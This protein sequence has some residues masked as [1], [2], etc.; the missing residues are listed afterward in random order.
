MG[1]AKGKNRKKKKNAGSKKDGGSGEGGDTR[2][3]T[4]YFG[5]E[6]KLL[7]LGDGD[8]SFSRG[9]IVS[10]SSHS[11]HS[12]PGVPRIIFLLSWVISLHTPSIYLL[13]FLASWYSVG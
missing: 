7:V 11:S 3:K 2:Q 1:K 4:S 9:L 12:L 6:G 5:L 13:A 8:F 10:R